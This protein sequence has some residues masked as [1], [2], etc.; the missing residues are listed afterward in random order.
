MSMTL[1]HVFIK[2]LVAFNAVYYLITGLWPLLHIDSFMA[3]TGPKNDIWLVRMV[4]L[5]AASTGLCM[6]YS[7][8]RKQ[9]PTLIFLLGIL[10][11]ASFIAVDVVYVLNGTIRPI[12]LLDAVAEMFLFLCYI[13]LLRSAGKH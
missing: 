13:V 4:G 10:N 11:A 12:Y 3:V 8:N 1:N 9:F 7:A 5:L 6:A 2:R